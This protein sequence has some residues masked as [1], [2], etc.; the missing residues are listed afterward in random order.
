MIVVPLVFYSVANGG[1]CSKKKGGRGFLRGLVHSR[2]LRM[3]SKH[4]VSYDLWMETKGNRWRVL[5]KRRLLSAMMEELAGEAHISIEGDL[6]AMSLSSISGASKEETIA[7]S[8]NTRW[9]KQDFIVLPL[10][11]TTIKSILVAMGGTVPNSVVHVQIEKN[12][13]IEFAAYDNFHP[14]CLLFGAAVAPAAI[15]SL[16][17]KS[18]M[19]PITRGTALP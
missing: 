15:E 11:P 3:I 10:E 18:I 16:L 2:L 14:Q 9:P 4:V 7:L 6:S 5:D 13:L 1:E 8:R 12:D 19:R 17:T